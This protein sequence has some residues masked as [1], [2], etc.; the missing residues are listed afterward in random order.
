VTTPVTTATLTP[1]PVDGWYN[2][3]PTVTLSAAD[4]SAVPGVTVPQTYYQIDNQGY[5]LYRGPFTISGDGVHQLNYYSVDSNG[6]AEP[7][8]T[9]YVQVDT[10]PPV[11]T[12]STSVTPSSTPQAGTVNGPVTVTLTATDTLVPNAGTPPVHSLPWP[13]NAPS[14]VAVT[15][16][17]VNGVGP[18]GSSTAWFTY[19]GP[20]TLSAGGAEVVT[21]RSVDNAGNVEAT[22]TLTLNINPQV[23][24]TYAGSVAS[25]IGISFGGPPT[26]GNWTFL[27]G[28]A[29]TYSA[30]TTATITTTATSTALT[31]ADTSTNAPGHLVNGTYS[32][33]QALQMD[34]TDAAHSTGTFQSLGA[35]T[36]TLLTYTAPAS[37]DAVTINAQQLIAAT[38]PLH[39]GTYSK[40]FVFT[41]SVLTP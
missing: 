16:Y 5:N 24:Q 7:V 17:Q 11:T 36:T 19:T 9:Q 18:G 26:L 38:D 37:S 20:F 4:S 31:V 23:S 21:Y 33:P 15:Q 32:L 10:E 35:S 1:T 41:V 27:A 6:L 28:Q 34:A 40:T 2:Q 14:G 39:T 25:Q 8:N 3:N 22:H 30:S 13:P 12:A 29:G